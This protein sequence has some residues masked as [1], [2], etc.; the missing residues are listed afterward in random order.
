MGGKKAIYIIRVIG[1][2]DKLTEAQFLPMSSRYQFL[3]VKKWEI[4]DEI[5]NNNK[6][7]DF[8]KITISMLS[9]E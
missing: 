6:I 2:G 3:P 7:L 8:T 5:P 9:K 4:C 1:T